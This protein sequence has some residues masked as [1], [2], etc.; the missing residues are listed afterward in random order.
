MIDLTTLDAFHPPLEN[1]VDILKYKEWHYFNIIDTTQ[2]VYLFTTLGLSGNIYQADKS[3]ANTLIG[4]IT[5]IKSEVL[6][7]PFSVT[8]SQWSNVNPNLKI[9]NNTVTY[10][11]SAK[12]NKY[13]IHE[14][15]GS[16]VLD[17]TFVPLTNPSPV[18]T[19]QNRLYW[20]AV[21]PKMNVNG[22][23]TINK[24][25]DQQT[26]YTFNNATGYHDHN[27]GTLLWGEDF[28]WNWGQTSESIYST[29][30]F[31]ITNTN[32][33]VPTF[34][35][36]QIWKNDLLIKTFNNITIQQSVMTSIPEYPDIYF[37]KNTQLDATDAIDNI[38][39][40]FI[41]DKIK[42]ILTRVENG[43]NSRILWELIGTYTITGN[44]NNESISFTKDGYFEYFG[45][46]IV[47]GPKKYNIIPIVIV[48]GTIGILYLILRNKQK[49]TKQRYE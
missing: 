16:T 46:G 21:S 29:V 39:V 19:I 1:D 47:E 41:A 4:Y 25:I 8:D 14:E 36:I 42:P 49:K 37:P 18:L 6:G 43:N 27:W 12:E 3:I 30:F 26:I 7:A 11:Y 38:H 17:A 33:T 24:G 31:E 32:H 9:S 15:S 13:T 40:T 45:P 34:Q 44:I 2:N 10:S 48:T 28:G 20:L 5:P 35:N 22:T 23:L